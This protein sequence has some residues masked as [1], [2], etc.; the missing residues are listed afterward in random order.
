METISP[1]LAWTWA[2]HSRSSAAALAACKREKSSIKQVQHLP[3]RNRQGERSQVP[4][5]ELIDLIEG[6]MLGEPEVSH[7][8]HNINS[9]SVKP[10]KAS[11]SAAALR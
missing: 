4:E 7:Q 3:A 6:L 9:R 10:G 5:Q 11:A 8:N 1:P 2:S